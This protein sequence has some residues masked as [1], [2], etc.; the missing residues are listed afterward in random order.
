[1]GT[2]LPGS[3]GFSLEAAVPLTP[4]LA[5]GLLVASSSHDAGASIDQY[6]LDSAAL[7]GEWRLDIGR[8]VPVLRAGL[9][10]LLVGAPDATATFHPAYELGLSVDWWTRAPHQ[11]FAI[12]GDLRYLGVLDGQAPFPLLAAYS[13]RVSWAF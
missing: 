10:A 6:G 2:D 5:V 11:G 1:M 4:Q 13:V 7:V 3:V 8:L 12:G 9:G